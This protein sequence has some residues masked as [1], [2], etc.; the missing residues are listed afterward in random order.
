[1]KRF[2]FAAQGVDM[3]RY[4]SKI[5]ASATLILPG[6]R[7][8][9]YRSR[10]G[11]VRYESLIDRAPD[12][13]SSGNWIFQAIWKSPMLLTYSPPTYTVK[14]FVVMRSNVPRRR[15][16]SSWISNAAPAILFVSSI[17]FI[18]IHPSFASNCF[19]PQNTLKIA[20]NIG[21]SLYPIL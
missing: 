1:M 14:P 12:R 5:S 2:N 20:T 18:F 11:G 17:Q 6:R 13:T 21:S 15:C 16:R 4:Q 3:N 19:I 9:K 8:L 7:S 10:L